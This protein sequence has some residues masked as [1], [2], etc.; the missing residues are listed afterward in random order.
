M[1]WSY[2]LTPEEEGRAARIGHERQAPMY[3]KPERNRNYSEGDI[4]EQWQHAIAAGSEI[5]AARML[6][7][8]D[9][10]PHVNTFKSRQDIPN[11]E[12]RYCF[13]KKSEPKWG[14][15]YRPGVDKPSE[16]Y[17]L[18]VGGPEYR[19]R[20]MKENN[21]ASPPY[22]AIGWMYGFQ[23]DGEQYKV[24]DTYYLVPYT[25]LNTM[26]DLPEGGVPF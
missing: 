3:G 7:Y 4:W 10:E 26:D 19:A 8:L 17:I 12:V 21:Y 24:T 25:S 23:C 2:E 20:R 11:Y 5:A 13:T 22:R 9:F 16:V 14:L 18:V 1:N 15:R 6:G